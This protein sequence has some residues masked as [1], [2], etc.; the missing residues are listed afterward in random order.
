MRNYFYGWYLKCQSENQTLAVIPAVHRSGQKRS[1]SIQFITKDHAWNV[2]YPAAAFR[3]T[4]EGIRIGRNRFGEKG[5]FLAVHTPELTISGKLR[6]GP[7]SP[8]KYDIMGPFSVLPFLECRHSVRSMSHFVCGRIDINGEE[9]LF[10]DA[11]GYWEGDQ[12]RSFPKEYV[13]TQCSFPGGSLM[14]SVADVPIA[15][16][17]FRGVISVVLWKGR[18]YRLATYL[19]AKAVWTQGGKIRIVQGNMELEAWLPEEIK[20][21]LKAPVNG[22][23]KRTIHESAACRVRYRFRKAGRTF[24]SF[25]T[26][27]AS[28]EYE[29]ISVRM[30]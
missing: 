5:I 22:E 17:D 12:G 27:Q 21:P 25:T 20:S 6:F 2:D 19:G 30:P 10:Q 28:V 29:R 8:L 1:C 7:L 15:G 13:W 4:K 3:R 16:L 9:Y 11:F 26:D 23:M 14:L 24:F 18:Q